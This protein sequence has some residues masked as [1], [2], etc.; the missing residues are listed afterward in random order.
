MQAM[1]IIFFEYSGGLGNQIFQY[2]QYQRM[3]K[4]KKII[5]LYI[6][7]TIAHERYRLQDLIKNAPNIKGQ[8]IARLIR[9]IAASSNLIRYDKY[10]WL[11]KKSDFHADFRRNTLVYIHGLFQFAPNEQEI[12]QLRQ[13]LKFSIE[14]KE[15]SCMHIRLGDYKNINVQNEIGI[16]PMSYY[17][18]AYAKLVQYGL[19]VFIVSDGADEEIEDILGQKGLS[20][21]RKKTDLEEFQFISEARYIS[22]TNSS[23]SISAAY[24]S[25]ANIII[26]PSN[27]MPAQKNTSDRTRDL[28]NEKFVIL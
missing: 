23:F 20:I 6:N 2:L 21:I 27:W 5:P 19:P 9:K 10:D 12:S 18:D 28:F 7:G 11:A 22:I 15:Y 17:R 14:T 13:K 3:S 1:N 4:T 16:Q 24:L 26:A 25:F 8:A